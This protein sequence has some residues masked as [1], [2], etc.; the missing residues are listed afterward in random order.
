MDGK[1]IAI[2][3]ILIEPF[4]R[5]IKQCYIYL[6]P[7]EDGLEL[8]HRIDAFMIKYNSRRHKEIG[9]IAPNIKRKLACS[10]QKSRA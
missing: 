9:R 1:G 3:N 2:D 7:S 4:W 5:S 8:N 10:K 6:N